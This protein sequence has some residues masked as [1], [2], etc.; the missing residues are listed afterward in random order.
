MALS[1]A[2]RKFMEAGRAAG[3]SDDELVAKVKER[4]NSGEG[5]PY[6]PT[7]YAAEA[8]KLRSRAPEYEALMARG[9]SPEQAV[10]S[11]IHTDRVVAG[12]TPEQRRRDEDV[13]AN[14]PLATMVLAGTLGAGA[15]SLVGGAARPILAGAANSATQTAVTGGDLEDIGKGALIGAAIPAAGRIAKGIGNRIR[16]SEGGQARALWEKHGGNVGPLDSGSGVEEI[17]GLEPSRAN[18]GKASAIG[19]RNIRR[20]LAEDFEQNVEAPYKAA[21]EPVDYGRAGKEWTDVS[22]LIQTVGEVPEAIR[23]A[24]KRELKDLGAV[25]TDDGRV[26]MTHADLNAAKQ[27]LQSLARYGLNTGAGTGNINDQ[28]FKSLANAAKVLVDEGPYAEANDIYERGMNMHAVDRASIGLANEPA[29][30]LKG[31]MTEDA[32][33]AQILRSRGNDSEAAGAMA[34][35]AD[36]PGFVSRHPELERQVDLPDLIRAKGK[37]E[38]GLNPDKLR[39]LNTKGENPTSLKKWKDLVGMNM[40]ALRGRYLYAPAG[41]AQAVGGVAQSAETNQILAALAAQRELEKRRAE[42]LGR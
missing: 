20:G 19:A 35:R 25:M 34:E 12:R 15:G 30:L 33:V 31:R 24:I 21:R 11:V 39:N 1:A 41:G 26:M 13:Y 27:R 28:S 8:D 40:D 17:A 22:S 4:R 9:L 36:V 3:Y 18:V 14:D 7:N 42:A 10:D 6:K 37:L 16:G 5:S 38:F 2:E 32:K 29:K 23:P